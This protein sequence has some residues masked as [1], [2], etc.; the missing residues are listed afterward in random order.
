MFTL[1]VLNF[2]GEARESRASTTQPRQ[3]NIILFF[4]L[5]VSPPERE[6]RLRLAGCDIEIMLKC[7]RG[8]ARA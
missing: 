6:N 5:A 7:R 4:H 2:P 8:H 1:W 3:H